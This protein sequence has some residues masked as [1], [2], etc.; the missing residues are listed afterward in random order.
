MAAGILIA[1]WAGLLI[2][3]LEQRQSLLR[4][5]MFM[6][7]AALTFNLGRDISLLVLWPIIFACFFVPVTE[8]WAMRRFGQ[9]PKLAIVVPA[10]TGSVQVL[11]GWVSDAARPRRRTRIDGEER[12]KFRNFL[13][14]WLAP[15]ALMSCQP[16]AS[17]QVSDCP[18]TPA[19]KARLSSA[20][21]INSQ[22]QRASKSTPCLG[23]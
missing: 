5:M 10:N 9:L 20:C 16:G 2:R 1:L 14:I 22:I 13:G 19:L 21:V 6:L 17:L 4:L 3:W 18:D 12:R 23:M 15:K 11:A 8:V 7:G